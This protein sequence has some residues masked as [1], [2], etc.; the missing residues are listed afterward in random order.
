[1]SNNPDIY[2]ISFGP[3]M[4]SFY[5]FQND[6][7][8]GSFNFMEENDQNEQELIS[9]SQQKNNENEINFKD[10]LENYEQKNENAQNHFEFMAESYNNV[11]DNK[12]KGNGKNQN[13]NNNINNEINE[14]NK[15]K[16]FLTEE[17]IKKTCLIKSNSKYALFQN[18]FKENACYINVVLHF[19]ISCK[20]ISDYLVNLH[21]TKMKNIKK[22]LNQ[23]NSV[24]K[25]DKEAVKELEKMEMEELMCYLGEIFYNYSKALNS[26]NKVN[27]LSTLEFRKKLSIISKK[28]KLNYVA[29]P[30]EFLIFLLESLFEKIKE[31][32]IKNFYLNMREKYLC[33]NCEEEK[34]IK[35]DK[36][37]FVHQ[38]YIEEVLNYLNK[39][40]KDFDDYSEK[41][42]L[43][44]QLNYLNTEQMCKNNHETEK[45]FICET[46]PNYLIINCVWAERPNIGQVLKL[47]TLLSLKNKLNDLFEIPNQEKN[48][49]NLIYDLTHIILYSFGLC[50][51]I[52]VKYNPSMKIFNLLD[53]SKVFE[54]DNFPEII[55][56]LTA[57]LISQNPLYYFYPVLLIYS[58]IEIYK[59]E[60]IINK[61]KFE[62]EFYNSLID[63]I[64]KSIE[65]Y[66][67]KLMENK[68][69]NDKNNNN[70]NSNNKNEQKG[71][72]KIDKKN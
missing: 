22:S 30:V 8:T 61:N 72:T 71:N 41:L 5:L 2:K 40:K 50:H 9:N 26:K 53:D 69:L 63:R 6:N 68:K 43:Y 37:T 25:N 24:D 16:D 45:R 48:N 59:D 3:T 38:I 52:I 70:K 10:M 57:N 58:N 20:N 62:K 27:I 42:F 29:D 46:F 33:P 54:S 32:I 7:N 66:E 17:E 35:Y 55:E 28:F 21:Q 65:Q 44:S 49:P 36:T 13:S 23:K 60:K 64:R 39:Q 47:F 31:Q 1:M 15:Q 14:T 34:E 12:I 18:K 67:K 56:M 11:N 51:Y 19:I 4:N